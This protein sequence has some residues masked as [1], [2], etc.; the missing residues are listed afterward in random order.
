MARFNLEYFIARRISNRGAGKRN[1]VMVRIATLSVVISVA[2]MIVSLA[3]TFGFKRSVAG[4]L[5]DM[6]AHVQIE[7]FGAGFSMEGDPIDRGAVPVERLAAIRDFAGAYP[8]AVKA[9][10]IRSD[11]AFQGIMLKGVD[12]TYDWDFLRRNLHE[13]ALP[14][15]TDTARSRDVLISRSLAG[16]ME[17]GVGDRIEILFIGDRPRQDR[18]RVSG[19]YDGAAG[20]NDRM[21]V[22]TDIR[23]V[24]RLNGWEP[25]EV[26]GV[27]VRTSNF[28]KLDR[29]TEEVSDVV[30]DADEAGDLRV[31]N[32]KQLQPMVFDWL[33]THNVNA[34]VIITVMLLVA[35]FNMVAALLIILLERTSMIGI[36]KSLGMD[37][38]SLQRMFVI[39]SSF[40][41]LR[42]MFWGN[43]IG[44]GICLLQ[45]YT[46]FVKL[47]QAGYALS[48]VPI[49]LD[50]EWW[51]LLNVVTF[52]F[53]VLLLTLPTRII[54]LIL[55][56]KSLRFE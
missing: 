55:P 44:L 6:G 7:G 46:G 51:L 39:R 24:Q 52:V 5:I 15:I 22:M 47:D 42:G 20:D 41:I 45:K 1:N 9:G 18:Y 26:T 38:R 21:M 35:L 49:A 30:Y 3:V 28:P 37:N 27:G 17:L 14:A 43:V 56:E 19:I 40:V 54:S 34:A 11:D 23:N 2:V 33:K 8:Y 13:G 29:F 12:G 48:R 16:V 36:L 32:I 50:W 25:G 4:N 31:V 53:I 10:I